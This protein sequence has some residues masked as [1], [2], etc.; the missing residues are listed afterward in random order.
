MR[1]RTRCTARDG[2]EARSSQC[3]WTPKETA[4]SP[5]ISRAESPLFGIVTVPEITSPVSAE[6]AYGG[7]ARPRSQV[8]SETTAHGIERGG[9]GPIHPY[10]LADAYSARHP[11]LCWFDG[12]EQ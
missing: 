9:Q 1:L 4:G 8:R 3:Q 11:V 5:W 10:V 2:S 6:I 12:A 7:V